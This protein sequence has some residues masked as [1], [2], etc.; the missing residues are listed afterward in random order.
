M[1]EDEAAIGIICPPPPPLSLL[2]NEAFPPF[3]PPP[4]LSLLN[5]N[6][7]DHLDEAEVGG[8]V[9][10][11]CTV[12]YTQSATTLS[13]VAYGLGRSLLVHVAP[14]QLR[15][16]SLLLD[17]VQHAL[18]IFHSTLLSKPVIHLGKPIDRPFLERDRGGLALHMVL[19]YAPR[20]TSKR[21]VSQ[22]SHWTFLQLPP[23]TGARAVTPLFHTA[24]FGVRN[25][26]DD[27]MPTTSGANCSP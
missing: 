6:V 27:D 10:G 13:L 8:H 17:V 14:R 26:P 12:M 1:V 24:D 15:L 18:H 16:G 4:P 25:P 11:N 22:L 7:S 2:N 23:D 19:E 21:V 9:E 20:P 3:P 5:N